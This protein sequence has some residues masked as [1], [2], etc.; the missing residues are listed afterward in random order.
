MAWH[1]DCFVVIMNNR[2]RIV[3]VHG[4]PSKVWEDFFQK[5]SS[6]HEGTKMFL[7]KKNYGEVALN[8]RTNDQI[9]PRFGRRFINDK[10]IFQ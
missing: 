1:A 7:G 4:A 5:T 8:W 10:Y 9:I 6:H 2:L 3:S